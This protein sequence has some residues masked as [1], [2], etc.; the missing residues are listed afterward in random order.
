MVWFSKIY[1]LAFVLLCF[2]VVPALAQEEERRQLL[3]PT[4]P[5]ETPQ[6]EESF[7]PSIRPPV[8]TAPRGTL[9]TPEQT[10]KTPE[11]NI[12]KHD[13]GTI[14][15]MDLLLSLSP[16]MQKELLDE[17][18][19]AHD[20]CAQIKLYS[21][22]H[23]CECIAATFLDERM[24]VG[25]EMPYENV[26][27]RINSQCVNAPGI[28]GHSYDVCYD[29]SVLKAISDKRLDE[30]CRCFAKRITDLYVKDPVPKSTYIH[31]MHRE[32]LEYCRE[33]R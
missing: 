24:K 6:E 13:K 20:S 23:D 9:N 12:D 19:H 4:A 28:A 18:Q 27:S 5:E 30:M 17:A 8:E 15:T 33:P 21:H 22:F 31:Y 14:S 3:Q 26:V 10:R 7:L 32:A 2:H 11:L 25:M 16:E 29:V 1:L